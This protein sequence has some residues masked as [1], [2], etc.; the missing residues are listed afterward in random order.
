[1]QSPPQ[2]HSEFGAAKPL[3]PKPKNPKTQTL[4]PK[5]SEAQTSGGLATLLTLLLL[6][7][8]CP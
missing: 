3:N 5:L 2:Q 1:M 6:L 7:G 4:N 8:C